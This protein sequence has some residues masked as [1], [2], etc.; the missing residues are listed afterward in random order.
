MC[1]L[2]GIHH[3]HSQIVC[4]CSS[5]QGHRGLLGSTADHEGRKAVNVHVLQTDHLHWPVP[6]IAV[7]MHVCAI[8]YLIHS[9]AC[10]SISCEPTRT[11]PTDVDIS[12]LRARGALN[13]R[14]ARV[15]I[16]SICVNK[17]TRVKGIPCKKVNFKCSSPGHLCW[18]HCLCSKL[19]PL[20]SFPPCKAICL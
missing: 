4:R 10:Q 11:R 19:L 12:S 17:N 6:Q 1:T 13:T 5:P 18:L 9:I 20:H 15:R 7:H 16:A 3:I 8:A 2:R 14:K